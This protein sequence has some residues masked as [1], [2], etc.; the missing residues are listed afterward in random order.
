MSECADEIVDEEQNWSDFDEA[1]EYDDLDVP[2][3]RWRK[4]TW[5]AKKS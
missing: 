5:K 1:S 2:E 3:M 4:R